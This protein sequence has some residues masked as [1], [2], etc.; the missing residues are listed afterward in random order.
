MALPACPASTWSSARRAC[1]SRISACSSALSPCRYS[2]PRWVPGGA[3]LDVGHGL[4]EAPPGGLGLA[5]QAAQPHGH[6]DRR[7]DHDQDEDAR[8]E[9]DEVVVDEVHRRAVSQAPRLGARWA[10]VL[11][12]IAETAR[13]VPDDRLSGPCCVVDGP[14]LPEAVLALSHWP[15]SGTPEALRADTSAEIAVRY[16]EADPRG[17]AVEALTNNHFDED[18]LFA[19][20]AA[21]RAA[22]RRRPARALAVAAAEA[23]DFRTWTDPWAA[24]S[25]IA[26]MAMAER[27]TTPF[28]DVGRA[29]ARAAARRSRRA[30]I[31][32]ALLPRIGRLL[33]DPG[34]PP[35]AL[36]GRRGSGSRPTWR[37][38]TRAGRAST[39]DPDGRPG[40][41]PH[42][43][44]P[45]TRWPCTRAPTGRAC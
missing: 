25:R 10:V 23:G 22:A 24:R 15:G 43:R 39:E 11:P 17:P 8:R 1:S 30:A 31:Y 42:A 14:R 29:L 35:D 32:Q 34:P 19:H 12:R 4:V 28:P 33:A 6:H 5:Q 16:L 44:V 38:S 40:D 45:S 7:D 2:M 37:C 36:G 26:A 41:R 27:G 3:G 20:L 18:G 9:D 13:F 21:A